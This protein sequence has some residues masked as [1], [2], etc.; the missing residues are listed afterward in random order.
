[1]ARTTKAPAVSKAP[2]A[3]K[4]VKAA[5][6]IVASPMPAPKPV[7]IKIADILPSFNAGAADIVAAEKKVAG[8][9]VKAGAAVAGAIQKHLDACAVAGV[10]RDKAGADAI[11]KAMRECEVFTPA[12]EAGHL[13]AKTITEYAQS[14][15]RAYFH[16]V[17]FSAS[18]KGNPDFKIPAAD[19]SVKAGGAVTTTNQTAAFKTAAKLLQQLRI[20]N[21]LDA[22]A[23]VLDTMLDYFPDFAEPADS[24]I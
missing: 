5:A 24:D 9:M 4:A 8:V 13:Q 20:L 19:G 16:N 15:A 12:I 17:P 7:K 21:E 3:G 23:A 2:A 6:P 1:M 11:A 18:L 14:A 22:A 10:P